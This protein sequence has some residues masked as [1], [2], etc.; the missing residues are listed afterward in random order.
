VPNDS[1]IA[2][3]EPAS[4]VAIRARQSRGTSSDAIYQ[5]V[6]RSLETRHEG[7]GL[8]L[9]VGCGAGNLWRFLANRFDRYLG[10]DVVR[11]EGFPADGAFYPIDLD[12]QR[13]SLPDGTA[14]VV[15]AVETIEHLE[16]PRAFFRELVRLARPGG[17]I[18]VTTPNQLSL[19]SKLTLVLKNQFNAFQEAEGGYPSH[20]TALL[21]IDLRRIAAECG[22]DDVAIRYS[23]QGRIPGTPWH[24]PA[25]FSRCY[26]RA[27]SDNVL[28]I[29]R[30]PYA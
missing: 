1:V 16:N 24:Y 23:G 17:W 6:A 11:Y 26:P 27:F 12:T 5:M 4:S 28:V 10:V 13:V 7:G 18:V 22:L 14:D 3:A 2:Q 25:L 29:G 30:K 21:E 9:D 15:A 19:L 20:L 8:L